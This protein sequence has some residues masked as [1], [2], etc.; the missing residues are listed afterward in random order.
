MFTIAKQYV[1]VLEC[2]LLVW[3]QRCFCLFC[4]ESRCPFTREYRFFIKK[5]ASPNA[6]IWKLCLNTD[7]S[8]LDETFKNGYEIAK[9]SLSILRECKNPLKCRKVGNSKFLNEKW[10]HLKSIKCQKKSAVKKVG[11]KKSVIKKSRQYKLFKLQI[12]Q[13]L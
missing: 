6:L 9:N 4:R 3:N 7:S 12:L 8:D 13:F 10:Q 1:F 2:L 11:I 5:S